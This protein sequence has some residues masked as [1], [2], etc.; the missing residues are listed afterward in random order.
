[1][2]MQNNNTFMDDLRLRYRTGGMHI[3]LIFINAAVFITLGIATV[4]ARLSGFDIS[5]LHDIFALE[6]NFHG[7]LTKPWGLFT[8]IFS[9]FNFFHFLFNMLFLYFAGRMLEQFFGGKRLLLIYIFGGLAGGLFE[10]LAH[11]IFPGLIHQQSVVVGASG[12]IMAIFIALAFYRPNLQVMLIA[13]PIKIIYLAG[14]Y[15][16]IDF[17]SLGTN[18]GTAHFAH[19]GGALF[20]ILSVKNPHSSR[21]IL[22]RM[23]RFF[24]RLFTKK[25]PKMTVLGGNPRKTDYEYNADKKSRQERTDAIL[26]KISRSGYESLTKAEKDF[27]FN[28]SQNG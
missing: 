6:A 11:E 2:I 3:K 21:N 8:S 22:A 27:L 10:V 15:I 20:G 28:Q 24:D 26:D 13:F 4:I 1:M 17:L 5:F 18:D 16:L 25:K 23:E 12:S 9:H 14:I 7:L 19:L